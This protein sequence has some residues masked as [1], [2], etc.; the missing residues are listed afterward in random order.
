MAD[1][2]DFLESVIAN[3]RIHD[4]V[5]QLSVT[6]NAARRRDIVG[7]LKQATSERPSYAEE[8]CMWANVSQPALTWMQSAAQLPLLIAGKESRCCAFVDAHAG[9]SCIDRG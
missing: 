7:Q 3:E 2:Q 5:D 1:E 4:W 8:V 9:A 6:R